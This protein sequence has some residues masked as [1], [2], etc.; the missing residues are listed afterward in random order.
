M[1]ESNGSNPSLNQGKAY[2][3]PF[4]VEPIQMSTLV[5]VIDEATKAELPIQVQGYLTTTEILRWQRWL[6]SKGDLKTV[7]MAELRVFA[8]AIL[9]TR[10][11]EGY[12]VTYDDVLAGISSH[13]LLEQIYEIFEGEQSGWKGKENPLSSVL[14]TSPATL[15]NI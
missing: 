8:T 5:V 15:E 10:T 1:S 14:E 13:S 9:L 7:P 4:K 12:E 6:T 3:V 2:K 11:A